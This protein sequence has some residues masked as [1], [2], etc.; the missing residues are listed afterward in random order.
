MTQPIE[1]AASADPAPQIVDVWT[2][3]ARKYRVRAV[4]MLVLIAILFAGLCCFMFWLRTG[5]Y[6]P[7]SSDK[8]E[9]LMSQSFQPSGSQQITLTDFLSAPISVKD[10]PIHGIIMGLLLATL[11]CIPL[12]VAILYRF[13][14]SVPFG[15]MVMFLAAMP[16]LGLTVLIGCLLTALRPFRLSFRFASALIGLIPV[17]IY[18]VSASLE[19]ADDQPRLIQQQA[20]LY[21]PWVLAV[22][23]S[24]VIC[25]IAL[26]TARLINYRPGGVAPLLALL[27][28]LPVYLFHTQVGVDELEYRLLEQEIG[29]GS[30]SLFATVDL[31]AAVERI[32]ARRLAKYPNETYDDLHR[33]VLQEAF[34][35]LHENVENDRAR[36]TLRC[37]HFLTYYPKSRYVPNVV[38]LKGRA[39][40]ERVV[41]RRDSR[42]EFR[43]DF[44]SRASR[45]TWETLAEKFP[46]D[47]ASATALYNL[48]LLSVRDGPAK[49]APASAPSPSTLGGIDAAVEY[50]DRLVS[51]FDSSKA[52][53]QGA[54]VAEEEKASVFHKA[55]PSTSLG[56]DPALVARQARRLREMLLACRRDAPRPRSELF[57]DGVGAPDELI[58]PVQLLLRLDDADPW[59]R[60]NLQEIA[61]RFPES[62]TGGYAE[63]R[64]ALQEPAVS[65]RLLLFE[66]TAR[67]WSGKPVG[68]EA[69]YYLGDVLQEDSLLKEAG[70]VFEELIKTYPDSYW[71]QEGRR[72]LASLAMLTVPVD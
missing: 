41:L 26:A 48:A 61:A 44:P 60:K 15:V 7:L 36:A 54:E 35:E 57:V 72:R 40:D 14:F 8:Y 27:F 23:G 30:R 71:A 42:V 4:L 31:G 50:L 25:A 58:H 49:P 55:P 5:V 34:A 68:A 43:G 70:R 32:V 9:A 21:A 33:R 69:L 65:R 17:S 2:R 63:I 67:T 29:P 12:L 39:Q 62:Q 18:F 16:W 64:L 56:V 37:D 24:C 38:F 1:T 28:A 11:S 19:P 45:T 20:L 53:T 6:W 13:P 3:T 59:Y 10:V 22:L 47:P 66:N 52:T 51:T 46:N